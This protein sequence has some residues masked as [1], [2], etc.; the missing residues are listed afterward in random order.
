MAVRKIIIL[1][2]QHYISVM[3]RSTVLLGPMKVKDIVSWHTSINIF[4]RHEVCKELHYIARNATNQAA[5][6]CGFVQYMVARKLLWEVRIEVNN[7]CIKQMYGIVQCNV[8][9]PDTFIKHVI[10]SQVLTIK[11]L[12]VTP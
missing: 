7:A 8:Y 9:T 12:H 2:Q 4:A 10:T 5:Q 3:E 11:H 1:L 6:L